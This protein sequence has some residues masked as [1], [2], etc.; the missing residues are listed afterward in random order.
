VPRLW[1]AWGSPFLIAGNPR[2]ITLVTAWT[3]S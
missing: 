2:Y 3:G 1:Q